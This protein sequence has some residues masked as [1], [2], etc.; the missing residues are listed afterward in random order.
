MEVFLDCLPCVLRQVLEASRLATDRF[1]VQE[2]IMQEATALLSEYR[3][4]RNAPELGGRMHQIVKRHTGV[5]DP[6]REVKA[7]SIRD[8]LQVYPFLER[9]LSEQVD[10]TERLY[11]TLKVAATGNIIDAA[12]GDRSACLKNFEAEL[13]K[14]FAV[15]DLARFQRELEQAKNLLIIGDNAGETV[16]DRLLMAYLPDLEIIYAVRGEPV[17]NDA[18]VD[19]VRASGFDPR[20]KV[21]STG[22]TTPGLIL[23]EC[24]AE[25]VTLFYQAD[26]V[27]SKG[28]GNFEALLDEDGRDLFFLLKAKCPQV[29][30]IL[31]VQVNDYV[32][33]W[34]GR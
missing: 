18:T 20:I 9:Y 14:R 30:A 13:V 5:P 32:F 25:F 2:A 22:A 16:F 26:L 4:F 29:A 19:D 3:K 21:V 27:I 23:E 34:H 33:K 28:Q 10:P 24:T 1:D 7:E 8:A 6:Y 12:L 11:W 31:G 15:C 17:I